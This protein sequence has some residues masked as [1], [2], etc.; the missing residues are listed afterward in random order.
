MQQ[1]RVSRPPTHLPRRWTDP[2]CR[3]REGWPRRAEPVADGASNAD[4]AGRASY[5]R[6]RRG[7]GASSRTGRAGTLRPGAAGDGRGAAGSGRSR[8][9]DPSSAAARPAGHSGRAS[10]QRSLPRTPTP[11]HA[12]SNESLIVGRPVRHAIL[13]LIPGMN[14]RLHPRSVAPAEGPEKGGPRRP[15]RSGYS[16]NNAQ[17]RHDALIPRRPRPL[18]R[19][20]AGHPRSRLRVWRYAHGPARSARSGTAVGQF[21]VMHQR[22]HAAPRT[23]RVVGSDAAAPRRRNRAACG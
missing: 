18:A 15:T 16:C 20:V 1:R 9:R 8:W 22:H 4:C 13:R 21:R 17:R 5:S 11:S 12:A 23:A 10:R 14:L 19:P 6:G 7:R 3:A 2:C